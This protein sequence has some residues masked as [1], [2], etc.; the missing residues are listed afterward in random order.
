[1]IHIW[2]VNDKYA[3]EV[4]NGRNSAKSGSFLC[5]GRRLA[6]NCVPAVGATLGKKSESGGIHSLSDPGGSVPVRFVP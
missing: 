6:W 1:V 5:D 4:Y 2:C 3:E